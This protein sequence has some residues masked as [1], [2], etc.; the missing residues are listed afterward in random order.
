M[1]KLFIIVLFTLFSTSIFAQSSDTAY[2][3]RVNL[4]F[5]LSQIALDGFNIE[6]NIF[7]DRWVFDYSHGASLNLANEMLGGDDQDQGLAVHI[8]YTTGFGLGY[9][10]TEWL[11]LRV[12]PKWHEYELYY[13]G[14][15]QNENNL[16][17]SYTTFT[18]GLGAYANIR[19]FKNKD[20]FL[21]GLMIA[22][23]VRWWPRV[24]STL[25]DNQLTYLNRNTEQMVT[26]E[27]RQIGMANTAFFVNLS[28]GY[29]ITLK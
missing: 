15:Q 6:G 11:N 1:Q 4:L 22:P 10:F 18:L 7:Y 23:S 3:T 12:E 20:N 8:P 27:A 9:Q 13:E 16:I 26:H 5:G 2:P 19:P 24:S 28:V 21:K 29:S 17:A 25:E 14:D